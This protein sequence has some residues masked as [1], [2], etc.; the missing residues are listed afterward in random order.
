MLIAVQDGHYMRE[1]DFRGSKFRRSCQPAVAK[2]NSQRETQELGSAIRNKMQNI[3]KPAILA[4]LMVCLMNGASAAE[5]RPRKLQTD[6]GSHIQA[7]KAS[8][9]SRLQGETDQLMDSLNKIDNMGDHVRR[10]AQAVDGPSVYGIPPMY[11]G[12]SNPGADGTIQPED[13]GAVVI[14]NPRS[15]R[16]VLDADYDEVTAVLA[17]FTVDTQN[18]ISRG[19]G[20]SP[21]RVAITRIS[22]GSVIVDFKLLFD[23]SISSVD[24]EAMTA[25]LLS[26]PQDVVTAEYVTKY[27]ASSVTVTQVGSSDGGAGQ[28]VPK[29]A[30]PPP[31]PGAASVA[32][33][34]LGMSVVLAL[35]AV[36]MSCL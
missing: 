35:L 8:L 6:F 36:L 26:N 17:E 12:A 9:E 24:I 2:C 33:V 31:S 23:N 25:R 32:S 29:N 15:F 28:D 19:L 13:G 1:P 34:S 22:P 7:L 20:L 21:S 16:M 10:F 27:G 5:I 4:F 3:M 11:S 14:P 30:S 18:A